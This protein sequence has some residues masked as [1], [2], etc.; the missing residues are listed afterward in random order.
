MIPQLLLERAFDFWYR[1]WLLLNTMVFQRRFRTWG[2][3]SRIGPGLRVSCPSAIDVGRNVMI[4]DHATL[5]VKEQRSDGRATLIIGDH[6][7]IGRFVHINA[8]LDVVIEPY[9]L[10][11]HRVLLGDEDHIYDDPEVPIRLQGSKFKGPVL[12]KTGCWIGTGAAILPGVTIGRNAVVAA[13]AVVTKDVPDYA[14]VAGIPA[15]VIKQLKG[16]PAPQKVAS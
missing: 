4:S 10:I 11:T 16:P 1:G 15:R 3:G 2:K 12:L 9:V 6:T 14:V 13:N 7:Y 8:W 5:N